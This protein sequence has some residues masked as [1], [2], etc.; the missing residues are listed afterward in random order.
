[1]CAT[2]NVFGNLCIH[3]RRHPDWEAIHG[4]D[5]YSSDAPPRDDCICDNCY[6]GRDALALEILKLHNTI[7]HKTHIIDTHH[8]ESV[9]EETGYCGRCGKVE[10]ICRCY[11][12]LFSD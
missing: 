10:S 5:G 11:G 12:N 1:M 8:H 6:Y 3:D 7:Q 4:V 9:C 2:I